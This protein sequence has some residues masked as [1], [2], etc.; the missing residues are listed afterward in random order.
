[1]SSELAIE[2]Q[3]R[4]FSQRVRS[5]RLP[6]THIHGDFL[7]EVIG[8]NRRNAWYLRHLAKPFEDKLGYDAFRSPDE[9]RHNIRPG[10]EVTL[11]KP[12]KGR[13]FG[14]IIALA[15]REM[16]HKVLVTGVVVVNEEYRRKGIAGHLAEDAILRNKPK[17]AT[18]RT[19]RWEVFRTYEGLEYQ[20]ER[21][22]PAITP[23]DTDGRL[24][25]EVRNQLVF[26]LTPQELKGLDLETG[27]YPDGT[28]PQITDL[29]NF[30]SPRNNPAGA[31]IF[32]AM[33][34]MGIDPARGNGLRYWAEL[35]QDVLEQASSAYNPIRVVIFPGSSLRD[36]LVAAIFDLPLVHLL[37]PALKRL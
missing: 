23:I 21:Y 19:R 24:P 7:Y 34:E 37:Q 10:G 28:Y 8:V 26:V 4:G 12:A 14:K 27:L 2:G 15:T 11:V 3:N 18:G 29:R 31:R 30:P 1:M 22:I 36:R 33:K 17:A 16:R 6:A 5:E 20:G 9:V 35:N 25:E 13:D 32:N